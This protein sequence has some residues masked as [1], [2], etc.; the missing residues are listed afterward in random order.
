MGSGDVLIEGDLTDKRNTYIYFKRRQQPNRHLHIPVGEVEGGAIVFHTFDIDPRRRV[1]P[2]I[3][4]TCD[5]S[6]LVRASREA[7]GASHAARRF[8]VGGEH[9]VVGA[10]VGPVGELVGYETA[11]LPLIR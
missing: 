11:L 10:R 8:G 1:W 4:C 5:R 2:R 6:H 7:R 9:G 3:G